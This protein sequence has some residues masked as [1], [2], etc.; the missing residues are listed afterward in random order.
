LPLTLAQIK[1]ATPRARA[2][3]LSDGGGLYLLVKPNGTRAWRYDYKIHGARKTL[4]LGVF[5]G[6]SVTEARTRLHEAKASIGRGI[7]PSMLKQVERTRMRIIREGGGDGVGSDSFE[8]IAREYAVMQKA[9]WTEGHY[10]RFIRRLE[11]N[12]FPYVGGQAL[13]ILSPVALLEVLRRVERRG[14]VDTAHRIRG[15]VGQ[16]MRYGVATGRTERDITVDLKG[17]LSPRIVTHRA[18]ITDPEGIGRLMRA[19]DQY[20]SLNV[21]CALQFCALTFA[22]PGEVRGAEWPEIDT[23]AAMWK[24]P[25][26]RMKKAR[27]HWVPLSRQ[28]L[29]VLEEIRPLSGA[30][31]LIFPSLRGRDRPLSN[32]TLNAALRYMG[33]DKNTMTSHGFRS[34]AS[35]RLNESGLWHHD[36][37]ELQ[38]AHQVGDA[39]RQ[40]Y[41]YAE[42]L[43][44]RRRMMQWWADYIDQQ[45]ERAS[46]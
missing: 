28:A 25:A 13:A 39:T 33:Y 10:Q 24:I 21:R 14:S 29:T 8:G 22:R 11:R 31:R 7:D 34:T 40:A 4:A 20:E 23:E 45:K 38:L 3:R 37:I 27:P 36:V 16:I 44:E 35:T 6:V 5:P 32:N 43:P 41:N 19:I 17:A 46:V 26:E 15:Y 42:H 18:S 12:V 9:K 1:R 30:G 2:F